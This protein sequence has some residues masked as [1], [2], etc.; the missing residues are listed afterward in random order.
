LIQRDGRQ[1]PL[2]RDGGIRWKLLSLTPN[3]K[4]NSRCHEAFDTE[5]KREEEGNTT[6]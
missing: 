1:R 5:T 3:E 6:R 4:I 2:D